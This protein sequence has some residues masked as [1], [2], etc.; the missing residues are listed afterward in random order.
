MTGPALDGRLLG[1]AIGFAAAGGYGARVAVRE[2]V[3]GEP[4]GVR[5]PGRVS[6]HLALAWGAGVSAPWPMPLA[7]VALALRR[8][9]G[10]GPG[11]ACIALGAA[12]L[13]GQLAEPVAWGRRPSTPAV[14]RSLALNLASCVALVLAG[15]RS[16]LAAH[17]HR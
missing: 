6:T 2:D 7:A 4:L 10:P 9:P 5:A 17:P 16:V 13:A 8:P 15:R 14:T 1:A 3:L 11:A 12:T